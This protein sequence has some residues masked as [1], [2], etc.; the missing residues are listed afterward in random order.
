MDFTQLINTR[1]SVRSYSAQPV[2]AEKLQTILEAGRLAPSACNNQPVKMIVVQAE[3]GL[4]KI[5]DG[6]KLYGAPLAI[7]VCGQRDAAWVRPFD[8]K[9]FVDVDASI[10]IDHMML[11]A[12][13]QGL[14][15][16][17]VGYFN[18]Q[19]I[20]QALNI[21]ATL[22][23]ISILAV[24]YANADQAPAKTRKALKDMVVHESF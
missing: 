23:P 12:T 24:G 15:T 20:R 7:V 10:V 5:K 4:T 22:E 18:P 6:A 13:E 3:T 16:L 11:A 19:I 17:W 9:S 8:G 21:P 2:E 14:G 1:Y